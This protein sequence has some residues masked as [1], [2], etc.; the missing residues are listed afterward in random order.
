MAHQ[1]KLTGKLLLTFI[2][3]IKLK[4]IKAGFGAN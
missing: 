3:K 1:I 4:H 2:I